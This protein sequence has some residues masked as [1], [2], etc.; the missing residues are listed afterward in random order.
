MYNLCFLCFS[1]THKTYHTEEMQINLTDCPWQ[2]H[3]I[4]YSFSCLQI[5]S[6]FFSP[7]NSKFKKPYPFVL[8]LAGARVNYLH[9]SGMELCFGF[10]LETELITW[11]CFSCCWA[12]L[13]QHPG[14]FC[15]SSHPA[16]EWA[17]STQWVGRGP[18]RDS[19]PQ[20]TKGI[21]Q[22]MWH[23]A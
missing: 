8:T 10:V 23:H 13:P 19:W 7:Q 3:F 9:I 5:C 4:S 12:G 1:F 11:R 22:N 15:S 16:S 14:L 20:W 2:V 6:R 17:G 18:S 21:S